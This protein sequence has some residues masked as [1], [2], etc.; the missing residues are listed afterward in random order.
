[1]SVAAITEL[2]N[3]SSVPYLLISQHHVAIAMYGFGMKTAM[4]LELAGL[5]DI[6][7]R[8]WVPLL[9]PPDATL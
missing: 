8:A 9:A 1:M 2:L 6:M 4:G 3:S 7:L 5:F